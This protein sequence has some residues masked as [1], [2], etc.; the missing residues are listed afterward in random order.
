MAGVGRSVGINQR[1]LYF[2]TDATII[3]AVA[4]E[5]AAA[6]DNFDAVVGTGMLV[7]AANLVAKVVEGPTG[8]SSTSVSPEDVPVLGQESAD[9]FSSL[10]S[11]EQVVFAV[12]GIHT[13][14]NVV[15]FRSMASNTACAVAYSEQVSATEWT[16]NVFTGS[17]A[18]RTYDGSVG[19]TYTRMTLTFN[20]SS[21]DK[22]IDQ[23]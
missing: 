1:D 21:E 6:A 17:F 18:G 12:Q 3:A 11:R 2:S 16:V 14:A 5:V 23:V 4:A 15:A 10:P 19:V 9:Q 22:W 8:V 20:R 13:D 7:D